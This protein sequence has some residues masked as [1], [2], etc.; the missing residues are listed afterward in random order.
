MN[1]TRMVLD[2]NGNPLQ[3]AS[4]VG[5]HER[6]TPS[7]GVATG[8]SN[9]FDSGQIVRLFTSDVDTYV[10]FVGQA[11]TGPTGYSFP[12]ASSSPEYFSIHGDG[13]VIYAIGGDVDI[14]VCR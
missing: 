1:K 7:E 11:E 13:V 3:V 2:S 14:N 6:L 4:P 8:T 9:T 12:L 5:V 10:S